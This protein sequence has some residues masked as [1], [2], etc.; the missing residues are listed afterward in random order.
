MLA[1][2]TDVDGTINVASVAI[3]APPAHGTA[4]ANVDGTVSYTHDGSETNNDSFTYTVADDLG[5]PSSSA[6]VT[7]IV[8]PVNDAPVASNDTAPRLP[9]IALP[10]PW[11]MTRG[12]RAPWR[13]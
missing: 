13:P 1:N 6:T 5:A 7:I 12:R 3:V 10:I 4:T 8:V 2:D 9:P 11:P